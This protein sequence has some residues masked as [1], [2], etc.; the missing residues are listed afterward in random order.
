MDRTLFTEGFPG[1]LWEISANGQ[2]DWAYI[3]DDLPTSWQ[4]SL[5]IWPLL[6]QAR[7]ELARLDGVGRTMPNFNLLLRPLQ[8]REALTSSSLEGTYATPE[9]LLLFEIDPKEPQSPSAPES[10][11]QEVQNYSN[12]LDLGLQMLTEMPLSLN[13]IRAIHQRLLAGVRGANKDPGN[14]R[15]TQVHIGSDR[16]FIPPP[17]NE[18]LPCLYA[19]EKSIHHPENKIDT[20]IFCFMA[21]YQFETIHPFLDGNGRVGRLL[22][23][24]MIYQKCNL[25][26][27][28]LY[29]SPFFERYKDEYINLLFQVSSKGAWISWI[30]FCLR[31]TIEQSQDAI[32]RIDKLLALRN[33]YIQ[34]LSQSGGNIRLTRLIE[35]LFDNSPAVTIAKVGQLCSVTTPT[36]T[37]DVN[38]LVSTGILV[39]SQLSTRPK[40]Y[41]APQIFKIIFDD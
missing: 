3:P 36:A 35:Y 11:W 2:L 8:R 7:E 22:L 24:L 14:F 1:R 12:A 40:V 9:Q 10:A 27:P 39:E 26:R 37:S 34:Q 28:W 32:K 41:I 33:Q 31:G 20:L 25:Q 5:E 15:R 21:H 29:L 6:T 13:V 17:P 18:V 16:R 19:L 4:P 30:K 38:R 23:S